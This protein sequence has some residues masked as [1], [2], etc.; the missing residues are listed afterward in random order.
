MTSGDNP[1]SGERG[2]DAEKPVRRATLVQLDHALPSVVAIIR[3]S[4][5][6]KSRTEGPPLAERLFGLETEYAFCALTATGKRA[7]MGYALNRFMEA[8]RE[9]LPHLPSHCSGGFFLQSGGRL[10]VDSGGHPELTTPE[11][12]NPW[13]ICRYVLAGDRLLEQVAQRAACEARQFQKIF[14]SRCNVGYAPGRC[15][16]WGCHENYA[17]QGQVENLAGQMIPHLVSRIIYTG[18]GGF[19]NSSPGIAF[20]ISPRVAFLQRAASEASTHNRGIF[21]HKDE[22]LAGKGYHRLHLLAGESLCSHRAMWL[23][24][25]VTAL[26]LAMVE[27][28][29]RPC[30]EIMLSSPVAAMARFARDVTLQA[31]ARTADNRY[32]TALQV[33]RHILAKLEEHA[34]HPIMPP[35]APRAR[36]LLGETLDRLEHGA[37]QVAR[38]LD[39]AIKLALF[40]QLARRAE[41]EWPTLS[42]W[43]AVL[44]EAYRAVSAALAARPEGPT[45]TAGA[46]L[47]PGGLLEQEVVGRMATTVRG[48]GLDPGQCGTVLR[49]RAQLL[50][51]DMRFSQLGEEGLFRALEQSGRL[52]HGVPGVDNIEHAM[53]NPPAQGR[54][55]LRGQCVQRFHHQHGRYGCDWQGVWDIDNRRMLD[56][57]DPL[58]DREHWKS[59]SDCGPARRAQPADH[60]VRREM[61]Y[62]RQMYDKGRYRQALELISALRVVSDVLESDVHTEL[63]RLTSWVQSRCGL[64]DS[65][66]ILDRL[67]ER[68]A[69]SLWLI[70]DY[71]SAYRFRGLVPEPGIA[72]WLERGERQLSAAPQCS[73][74]RMG[75][76]REH[77]GYYLLSEGQ[78]EAARV[79]LE[80]A[81]RLLRSSP[82][83]GRILSRTEA[84]LGEVYRRLGDERRARELLESA[85][86]RQDECRFLGELAEFSLVGL[87]KL[88]QDPAAALA[89]V[90]RALSIQEQLQ[91]SMGETRSLLIRSRLGNDSQMRGRD[92]ERLRSLQ[93]SVPALGGCPLLRLVLDHW[94][95]WTSGRPAPDGREDTFW[96]V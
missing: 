29:L 3:Q 96:G 65:I 58:A 5:V 31:R 54:A 8:A 12:V 42:E 79:E 74:G 64:L 49:L 13:D 17:Y 30:E 78:L 41:V 94:D 66:G 46:V 37:G 39:W 81:Q 40:Q 80:R 15:S 95:Q 71:V 50:E 62:L 19:D 88:E 7:D 73:P 23:K 10:Y 63:M 11:V 48:R 83:N 51:L 87:A 38:C 32:R 60:V 14:L 16:T 35:W 69:L 90:N 36:E 93:R 84:T 85:A 6:W 75:A 33:Q 82:E 55:R 34:N 47:K 72:A 26:V 43:N 76:F 67:A 53:V 18:A 68:H 89:H 52:D 4:L 91:H 25:G 44:A 92:H 1:R 61:R 77:R 24:S 57:S 86:R 9:H 59:M 22:T 45:I 20:M 70:T 56:L 21:H 28:G 27:A 2:Y